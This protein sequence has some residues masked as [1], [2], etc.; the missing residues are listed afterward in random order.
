MPRSSWALLRTTL[1]L[2]AALV[3]LACQPSTSSQVQSLAGAWAFHPGDDLRWA[4][5]AFDDSDWPRLRV[6]GSW[7]RQGYD[8]V[9][10]LAWYRLQVSPEW[11]PGEPLGVTIGKINAAYE[12]FVD[13]VKVGGVGQL[14]PN[15]LSEYDRYA[16]YVVPAPA[17]STLS[18]ALR[19]WRPPHRD[20]GD[21]GATGGP[22]EIGP[23]RVLLPRA[24]VGEVDRLGLALVFTAVGIYMFGLWLLRTSSREY[25]LFALLAMCAAGYSL[26]I[27][28]WKYTFAADFLALKKFEHLLL[29]VTP[30]V[31]IEFLYVFVRRQVPVALRLAQ[32]AFGVGAVAVLLS[33]G[34]E[35]ALWLLPWL[36]VFAIAT[37]L[38]WLTSLAVWS[39][40]GNRD[41]RT[42]G[43]GALALTVVMTHDAVVD[44]G[45]L[46]DPRLAPYGFAVLLIG[47]AVALAARFHH[48]VDGLASLSRELEARVEQRTVE[49]A[50]AYRRMEELAGRDSLTNLLNRR[51]IVERA[52]GSLSHARRAAE[53]YA[54]A[55]VDIDHFKAINDTHGHAA[56]DRVLA[57]VAAEIA[58]TVRAADDVSRWGGEEFL[59]LLPAS[60]GQAGRHA[61]ERVRAA[62]ERTPVALDDRATPIHFTASIGVAATAD[63]GDPA[64]TFDALARRAD[65]ALY[66]AKQSGR[67]A[68]CL[69]DTP[70]PAAEPDSRA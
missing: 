53:P 41:A 19:V 16:T 5:P 62:I 50:A 30:A 70:D 47:M 17:P 56:G 12:I 68:V 60:D 13:G 48:A 22:F 25:G 51:A 59:L 38:V 8:D 7:G 58:A 14:P 11:P 28:Q 15:P 66:R 10:G 43:V 4:D 31:L 40:Q 3:S 1:A 26:M 2:G 18:I 46:V 63:V 37:A 27:T 49:L 39:W 67:N 52:R 42:V 45:L 36:E 54:V 21:A 55:L 23:L 33:P 57:T 34:L 44:R 24:R 69:A 64:A 20:P 29:Y 65:E 61:M 32:V 9:I 6:P 35:L